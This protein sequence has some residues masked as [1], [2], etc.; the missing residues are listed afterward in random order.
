MSDHVLTAR[1]RQILDC[2]DTAMRDR[3]YPPSVR[4]IGETALALLLGDAAPGGDV[5]GPLVLHRVDGE[6]AELPCLL[7]AHPLGAQPDL[8]DRHLRL[9]GA[10]GCCW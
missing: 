1:Q 8:G 3:G 5:G 6:V 10:R 4:E 7:L 9:L 2:I